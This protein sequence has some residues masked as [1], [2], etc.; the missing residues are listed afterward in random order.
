MAVTTPAKTGRRGEAVGLRTLPQDISKQT[1]DDWKDSAAEYVRTELFKKQFV[2]DE[3][4]VA[5]G[6]IQVLVCNYIKICGK[7][8][9]RI[10]W[11]EKGVGDS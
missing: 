6:A 8:R 5:G 4:L 11:D 9:A 2:R 3:Q 7:E 1:L 10:F